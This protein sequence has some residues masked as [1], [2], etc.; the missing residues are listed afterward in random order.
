MFRKAALIATITLAAASLAVTGASAQVKLKV[1][2]VLSDGSPLDLGIKKWAELV[3]ERSNGEIEIQVFPAGQ[4]GKA[5]DQIENLSAGSQDLMVEHLVFYS[6]FDKRFGV[7]NLPYMFASRDHL[8]RFLQ[9][10]RFQQMLGDL[11]QSRGLKFLSAAKPNWIYQTDRTLLAKKPVF[12]PADLD[13]MKLRMYE[14]RVP[15]LSWQTLGANTIIL[16]WGETYTALATGTVEAITARVEA[17]YQMKQTEVAKFMTITREFYQTSIP[18]MSAKIHAKLTP[19]QVELITQASSDAGDFFT[20]VTSSLASEYYGRVIKEHGVSVIEVP[21][22]PW[23]D[24]IRPAY[25]TFEKEGI[26]PA[27]IIGYIEALK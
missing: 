10:E 22:G 16:P 9:S 8:K 20:S 13:G 2:H 21:I 1:G 15:V 6:N 7:L 26:I 23:Q 24:K 4:L 14:A 12:T 25:A 17:H 5:V 3:K 11:E 18:V 27:G 19:A